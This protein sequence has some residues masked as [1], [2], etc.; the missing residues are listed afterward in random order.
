[1]NEI[2]VYIFLT[3]KYVSGEQRL[4]PDRLVP[5]EPATS[6]STRNNVKYY[7]LNTF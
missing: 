2:N 6:F 5:L 7:V 4:F 3:G 1:M